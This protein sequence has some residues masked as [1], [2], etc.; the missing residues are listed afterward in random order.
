MP[1]WLR[2]WAGVS[3]GVPVGVTKVEVWYVTANTFE[4]ASKL[5]NV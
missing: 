1:D 5:L 2:A 4:P 3:G